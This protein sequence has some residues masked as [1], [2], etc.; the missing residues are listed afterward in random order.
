[1]DMIIR[2]QKDREHP[3]VTVSKSL[4]QNK[5][6]SWEARGMMVYLLGK[7]DDW[8]VRMTDLQ[9]Q[10]P[11]GR[12]QT[13]RIFKELEEHGFV[14]RIQRHLKDG[15]FEWET[16]VY[17]T[18]VDGTTTDGK[19]VNGKAVNIVKNDL[20]SNDI[21]NTDVVNDIMSSSSN[22]EPRPPKDNSLEGELFDILAESGVLINSI[23]QQQ[24]WTALLDE[25]KDLKLI[26][27][28][29]VSAAGNGVHPNPKYIRTILQRCV[30]QNRHPDEWGERSKRK[31]R[32]YSGTPTDLVA[33]M[34]YDPA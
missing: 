32:P 9:R 13:Q 3:W 24:T 2:V 10:S 22:P 4:T 25:T 29:F 18:P 6:L 15:T 1:M 28:A 20:P 26:R 19:A 7:P 31:K 21:L 11:A 12:E 14:R 16:T 17:E 8:Q 33:G 27:E 34:G 23:L 5:E 30:R